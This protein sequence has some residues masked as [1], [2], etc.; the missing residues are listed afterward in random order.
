MMSVPTLAAGALEEAFRLARQGIACFPCNNDKRPTTPHGFKDATIDLDALRQLWRRHPGILTGVPTGEPSGLSVI[1]VDARHG[2][3]AW[4]AERR[5][6]LPATRVH[7]TRSGGLHFLFRHEAGLRCSAGR[8]A[9]GVDV[10]ASG[11]YVIWWP[12][13]GLPI[14]SD[15]EI[16]AWPAWLLPAS[17]CRTFR[18]ARAPIIPDDVTLTRLVRVIVRA[19][20]G[21]RN[22]ITYWAACRAGDMVAS[23]LMNAQTAAAVIEE[24]ATRAGLSAIEARRTAWSG[25]KAA[26]EQHHG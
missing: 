8:V 25:I 6:D 3:A 18:S 22:N 23:G 26:R 7:R 15:C 10:R 12:A 16:A 20:T 5:R 14:L 4:I 17:E 2:G 11:G 13:A 24:A 9:P 21:E 1:D 19:R